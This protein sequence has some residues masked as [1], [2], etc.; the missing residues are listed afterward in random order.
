MAIIYL[1]LGS[2]LGDK[3]GNLFFAVEEI[4]RKIGRVL[5]KSNTIESESWGFVSKNRFMNMVLCVDTNLLPM[6]LLTACNE[7]ETAAGRIE[8]SCCAIYADRT[9]DIDILYYDKEIIRTENLTV[10]HPHIAERD[11]VLIPLCEIAADFIDPLT[12]KTIIQMLEEL[13]KNKR[14][15]I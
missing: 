4:E 10:P 6:E 1:G 13:S 7:I 12:G 3:A 11:F 15:E 2:N 5:A 14:S 9:L 8:K